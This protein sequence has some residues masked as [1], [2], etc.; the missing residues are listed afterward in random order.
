MIRGIRPFAFSASIIVSSYVLRQIA[1]AGPEHQEPS[2]ETPARRLRYAFPYLR[3][4]E[5]LSAEPRAT[6]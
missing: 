2:A 3:T 1:S 5:S 6:A 4:P